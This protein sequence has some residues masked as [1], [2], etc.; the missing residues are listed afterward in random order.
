MVEKKQTKWL[1]RKQHFIVFHQ[2]QNHIKKWFRRHIE[3]F[4]T[5][6]KGLAVFLISIFAQLDRSDFNFEFETLYESI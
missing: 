5:F 3:I 6:S 1:L 4:A 2:C